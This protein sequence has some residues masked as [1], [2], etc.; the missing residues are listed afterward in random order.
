MLSVVMAAPLLGDLDWR[1]VNDTVMGGVSRSTV[2][3]KP[4]MRF[5]GALS[6]EQNGGFVS[7]RTRPAALPLGDARA[8]RVTLRGD[9]RV[10]DLTLRRADVPLRA[11][12]YRVQIPTRAEATTVEVPLS[13]F[14]PTS[15]GRPVPGAP[16]LDAGLDRVV[17][18]G[19]LLAD[20]RPGPFE[21]EVL[22][23]EAVP[24]AQPRGPG[25][26]ALAKAFSAAVAEGVPAFNAGEHQRCRVVY[27]TALEAALA[28]PGPLTAGE[29]SIIEQAL[30]DARAQGDT[31]AAWTLRHAIDSVMR[32]A[33]RGAGGR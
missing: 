24:G 8:L 15:F 18:I 20:G 22:A 21:L 29:R 11:G 12:S 30:A 5:T 33:P 25:H 13:D 28:E 23:I 2:T 3:M 14:R 31:P 16:A 32:S 1:V 7:V 19:F 4:T 6:L 17:S 9:G 26:A 10:Y 27:A